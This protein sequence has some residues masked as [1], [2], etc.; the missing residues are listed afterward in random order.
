MAPALLVTGGRKLPNATDKLI[1]EVVSDCV[2]YDGRAAEQDTLTSQALW[3]ISR[4]IYSGGFTITQFANNAEFTAIWDDRATYF[5]SPGACTP[6]IPYPHTIISDG[7]DTLLINPDGSINVSGTISIQSV[8][9]ETIAN[10]TLTLANTEYSYT[11]PTLTKRFMIKS[12][13]GHDFRYSPVLGESGTNFLLLPSYWQDN[14]VGVVT[15]T[16]YFQSK[17]AGEIM[18]I[19][20]WV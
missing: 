10:V 13:S 17:N 20:S 2:R 16:L 14:V 5:S 6:P 7:T 18:E 19:S 1:S 15:R 3:Q 12:R 8:S 11:L 4:T 9:T